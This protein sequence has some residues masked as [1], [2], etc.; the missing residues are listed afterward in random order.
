MMFRRSGVFKAF[1]T[2]SIFDSQYFWLTMCLLEHNSIISWV[3]R[4]SVK[5]EDGMSHGD[6]LLQYSHGD[7][8]WVFTS[9]SLRRGWEHFHFMQDSYSV[10][11]V[12]NIPRQKGIKLLW[13]EGCSECWWA[14]KG[15]L[16]RSYDVF[17]HVH[18]L[19]FLHCSGS[20]VNTLPTFSCLLV[21]RFAWLMRSS[22]GKEEK[23]GEASIFLPSSF[24]LVAS[25]SRCL[26]SVVLAPAR[27]P[28]LYRLD[29][30]GEAPAVV[31]VAARH[32]QLLG[33]CNIT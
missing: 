17:S 31:L 16:C 28:S 8:W 21:C 15:G 32:P 25:Q 3:P 23:K 1:L 18:S 9:P 33:F 19:R 26:S 27:E 29:L 5:G 12:N 6:S 13:A 4:G 14:R 10:D 30:W 24:F 20:R 2:L 7:F 11:S 22:R